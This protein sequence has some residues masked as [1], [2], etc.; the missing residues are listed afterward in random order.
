[1]N[2]RIQVVVSLLLITA[3]FPL[4]HASACKCKE[5]ESVSI[6]SAK[7]PLIFVGKVVGGRVDGQVRQFTF[8]SETILKGENSASFEIQTG[9]SD[10]DCGFD[11]IVGRTYLVYSYE[12]LVGRH[13]DRCGRTKEFNSSTQ[14]EVSELKRALR[15]SEGH[16]KS[17][18]PTN[19]A[20]GNQ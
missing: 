20:Q 2:N 10:E 7:F 3:V 16:N 18:K 6:A 8:G 5:P 12:D 15:G 9:M 4:V 13:V 11:F 19:P 14:K 1:M 17:L